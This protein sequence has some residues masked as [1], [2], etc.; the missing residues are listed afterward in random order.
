[1]S[2]SVH[3]HL[4]FFP[5]VVFMSPLASFC[6]WTSWFS[7]TAFCSIYSSFASYFMSLL[8][9]W[10]NIQY[11]LI[12]L[13]NL[14]IIIRWKETIAICWENL[15][16]KLGFVNQ[17]TVF[18]KFGNILNLLYERVDMIWAECCVDA[19]PH[20]ILW[21]SSEYLL[22][23]SQVPMTTTAILELHCFWACL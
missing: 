23:Y 1:M 8:Y 5:C 4:F 22:Q 14:I 3:L 16:Q 15:L 18:M 17:N 7:F 21:H 19:H 6:C 2:E 9:N 10:C 13:L 12:S 11:T 20:F